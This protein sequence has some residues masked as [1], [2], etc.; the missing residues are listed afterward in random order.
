M[1]RLHPSRRRDDEYLFDSGYNGYVPGRDLW[2]A[3]VP[4]WVDRMLLGLLGFAVGYAIMLSL[5]N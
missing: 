1:K 4:K 2:L 5:I 3:Y